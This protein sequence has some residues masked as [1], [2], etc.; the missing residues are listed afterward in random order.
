MSEPQETPLDR[1][2]DRRQSEAALAIARGTGRALY[3]LGFASLAE[4]GLPNGRRADLMG[5][6]GK[7]ELWIVEIKSSIED[8]RADQKWPEYREF[9]DRLLFAV[10]PGFPIDILPA[11]T[12][13]ILADRYGGEMVRAAPEHRLAGARRK[14]ITLRFARLAALRLQSVWDADARIAP[15]NIP[16]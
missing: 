5:L 13:L 8:F 7:G 6:S 16:G 4:V 2:R 11:D 12:G 9:C 10:A 3:A 14:A 1:E 15:D